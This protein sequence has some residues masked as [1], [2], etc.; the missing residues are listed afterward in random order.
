[1]SDPLA[2]LWQSE[3]PPIDIAAVVRGIGREA[4]TQRRFV[5]AS[6]AVAAFALVL[7]LWI[8]LHGGV[9]VPGVLSGAVLAGMAWQAF[10]VRRAV[11]RCPDA[12]SMAPPDLLRHALRHARATRWNARMAYGLYPACLALGIGLGALVSDGI[13]DLPGGRHLAFAACLITLSSVIAGVVIGR[14]V[15]ASRTGEITILERRLKA[16]ED[17]V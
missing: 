16:L 12:A 5:A 17:A 13:A 4:R 7:A 9:V 1:M 10:A 2:D 15:A 6:W 11:R 3:A 14:R 8:D